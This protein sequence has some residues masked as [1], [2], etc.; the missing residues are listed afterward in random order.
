MKLLLLEPYCGGSHRAWA[1]GYVA[2]SRHEVTLLSLAA[3]FW[4]WRMHGG[5]VTLAERARKLDHRPDLIL[6][7]DMLNL[8]TFLALTRDFLADVP[9][10]LY[11]H[12][13][14]L[15]YPVPPGEKADLTYGMINWLS[16]LAADRVF[17]N[18]S[19]H[20]EDWF[21]A[22]PNMLKHFPDYTHLHRVGEVRAKA[23]VLPVGCDL[24]RLD[25]VPR[26]ERAG[27]PPLVL[28]N[29]RWEYDKDPQTFFRA[30]HAL[31]G[32]GV[33]FRVAIAGKSHRQTAP[34]FEAAKERLGDRVEHFGY[35][36]GKAYE[37]LL[38]GAAIVV[39][40][41]IHEFFGVSVVE[42]IYGG[43]FPVLPNHLSYPELISE[44]HHEV[45]LHGSFEELLAHLRWALNHP[46]EARSL[47][48]DL[49][50]TVARFDWG[51]MAPVYDRLLGESI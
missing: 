46:N 40:T 13:N 24:S 42:A 17:F 44:S 33:D 2:N 4:K 39:S 35:A 32:E 29:Q 20:L 18:S 16:M 12:E 37:R 9:T 1:E 30:L 38:R 41:A 15:T 19:Y 22:L 26:P 11:C 8:P 6:A 34:E 48:Q 10:V 7:S 25:A 51:E 3:R 49:R 5:S 27:E 43:C 21:Q 50:P 23:S 14:Q 36:E 28:W 31:Q 47:A 45:C